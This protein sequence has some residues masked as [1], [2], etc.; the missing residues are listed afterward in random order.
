M[1]IAAAVVATVFTFG[2]A[3][4]LL[5]LAISGGIAMVAGAAMYGIG[6]ALDQKWMQKL[7]T[8]MM[9]A[10][11]VAVAVAGSIALA[12]VIAGAVASTDALRD[13]KSVV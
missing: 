13:R 8:G 7:G 9:V 4:P 2:A 10:G 3:S 11:A 5:A 6:K 12:P 1:I